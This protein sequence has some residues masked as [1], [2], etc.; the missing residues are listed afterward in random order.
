MDCV[1]GSSLYCDFQPN[2]TTFTIFFSLL[3]AWEY[4]LSPHIRK[5]ANSVL[6]KS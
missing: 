2:F 3:V 6:L 1:C 5:V 4:C